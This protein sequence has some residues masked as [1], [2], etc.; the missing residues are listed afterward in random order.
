MSS[1]QINRDSD[2]PSASSS[3]IQTA[4]VFMRLVRDDEERV[5]RRRDRFI[6]LARH[7]GLTIAVI[8]AESGIPED[9]VEQ[10]IRSADTKCP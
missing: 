10:I 2:S 8:A 1:A 7:H 6:P 4:I 3:L 9:Q 5:A